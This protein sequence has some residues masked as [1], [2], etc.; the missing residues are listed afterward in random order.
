MAALL[1]KLRNHLDSPAMTKQERAAE[2]GTY[3]PK[4]QRASAPNLQASQRHPVVRPGLQVAI[5]TPRRT[6]DKL[7]AASQPI[8]QGSYASFKGLIKNF[9]QLIIALIICLAGIVTIIY[10]LVFFVV[11]G[12]LLLGNL[13]SYGPT[14]TA[15]TQAI[16]NGQ[17]TTIETSNVNGNIHITVIT[18]AKDGSTSYKIYS[19]PPLD[20]NAWND[21]MSGITATAEVAPHQINPT[22]TVHLI[23]N[24]NYFHLLFKRPQMTLH[25]IPDKQAGYKVIVAS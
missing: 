11:A 24:V 1:G 8:I 23:G 10:T 14:H 2:Y 7:Q 21:D 20:P 17:N 3:T 5:Q 18:T 25:L 19:G 22:I 12:C 16:I 4:I 6:T 15:Y 13:A 9:I